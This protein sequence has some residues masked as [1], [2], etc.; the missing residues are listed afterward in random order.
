MAI[1][2]FISELFRTPWPH[3]FNPSMLLK[4]VNESLFHFTTETPSWMN[5]PVGA[6]WMGIAGL[7]LFYLFLLSRNPRRTP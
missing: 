5:L 2:T 3:L 4:A 1:A 6:A 7:I